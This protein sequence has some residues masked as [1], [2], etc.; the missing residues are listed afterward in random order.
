MD[1][2]DDDPHP[3]TWPKRQASTLIRVILQGS[4]L[5]KLCILVGQDLIGNP[6]MYIFSI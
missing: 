5:S 1:D 3:N 6:K 4:T 2:D